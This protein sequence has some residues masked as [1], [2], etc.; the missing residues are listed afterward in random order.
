MTSEERFQRAG[1]LAAWICSAYEDSNPA[2]SDI[3]RDNDGFLV[4]LIQVEGSPTYPYYR[5]VTNVDDLQ[6]LRA[7]VEERIEQ[8]F[9]ILSQ[10]N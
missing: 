3:A 10:T 6:T 5:V 7:A 2:L 9:E 4:D 1:N 8:I